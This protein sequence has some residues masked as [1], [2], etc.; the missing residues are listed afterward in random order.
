MFL[1]LIILDDIIIE[2]CSPICLL[3]MHL[4]I[5]SI[6]MNLSN[7]LRDISDISSLSNNLRLELMNKIKSNM[8]LG[9]AK[10][11]LILCLYRRYL[12]FN[13]FTNLL[14]LTEILMEFYNNLTVLLL[15]I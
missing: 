12:M 6:S 9:F 10:P 11:L 3:K 4:H 5:A 13:S 14:M 2:Q 7:V 8:D 15:I 1:Y